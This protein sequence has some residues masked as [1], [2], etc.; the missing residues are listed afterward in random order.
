MIM[1]LMCKSKIHRA[2][3]KKVDMHYEGSIGIDKSIMAAA[4][5]LPYEMVHVL[6]VT[7]G[8]RFETYAITERQGSGVVAL[9]G[10]AA[11]LGALDDI[12][13]ILTYALLDE[14]AAKTLKPGI[15]R[16]DSAN[17]ITRRKS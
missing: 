8:A 10:A 11:H 5:I 3:I 4:D 7:N 12:V 14:K 13:I 17:R 1:R 16:V 2:R 15:V 9:Y 6:N